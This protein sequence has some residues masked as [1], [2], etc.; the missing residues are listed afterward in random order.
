ALGTFAAIPLILLPAE[1]HGWV[2]GLIHRSTAAVPAPEHAAAHESF[3]ASP[4]NWMLV[5]SS[6]VGISGILIA[7]LL[8]LAG[9]TTA[10]TS[11]ADSLIPLLGPIPR[12]A[13]NKW[14]VDELYD[15]LIRTPLWVLSHLFYYFD[16][17]IVDGL[18]N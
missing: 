2:G 15:F 13:Q 4:H 6:I 14:Y 9:R 11:R 10:A 12:L 8:H 5:V 7:W 1:T 3:W 18:V 17:L 16:M